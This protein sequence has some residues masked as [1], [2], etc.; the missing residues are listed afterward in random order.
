MSVTDDNRD[1]TVAITTKEIDLTTARDFDIELTTAVAH[2][3]EREA[4]R[5]ILDFTAVHFMDSGGV[6]QLIDA[7]NRLLEGGCRLE[8]DHVQRP[9]EKIL[10]VLGLKTTF[11]VV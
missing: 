11:A 6:S 5:L 10:D 9:V 7:R 3:R 4:D 2:A 8:L 1:L